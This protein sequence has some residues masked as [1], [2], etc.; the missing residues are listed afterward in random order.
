M[1]YFTTI[2]LYGGFS[3][4][5]VVNDFYI[6]L[7]GATKR[8]QQLNHEKWM[9]ETFIW[10]IK[11]DRFELIYCHMQMLLSIYLTLYKIL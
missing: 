10:V 1:I 9:I 11:E 3:L 7:N 4:I 8:R 6:H 2:S 5:F